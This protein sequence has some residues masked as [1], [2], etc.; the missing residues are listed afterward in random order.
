MS[1]PL[2]ASRQ[3]HM[4][5]RIY[6]F[7]E[8]ELAVA[9][10][11]LRSINGGTI[12]LQ[13]KPLLLLSA[14][15]DNPQKVVT[16]EQLRT[17][18][19][20]SDTFVDHEQGINVAVKKVRGAL[21]DSAEDPKFI[22]TVAKKGYRFLLPVEVESRNGADANSPAFVTNTPTISENNQMAQSVEV[23]RTE[24]T[25]VGV[26]VAG[27]VLLI[28]VGVFLAR[29][30]F[31]PRSFASEKTTLIVIPLDNLSGDPQQEYLSDGITEE[32]TTQLAR[33][34]PNRLAVIGRLTATRYKQSGKDIAQIGKE[35]PVNY[36]LEG[37]I[38]REG[39][40]LRATVQLIEVATQTHVWAEEYD[41]STGDALSLQNEIAAAVAGQIRLKLTPEQEQELASDS[42]GSPAAHD[43]YLRG[44][45]EWNKRDA[46]G[47]YEAIKYF[48]QALRAQP[49][50]APA[51]A[52]LADSYNLL[53]QYGFARPEEAYPQAKVYATKALQLDAGLAEAYTAL[54]DVEIKYDLDWQ[55]GERQFMQA[56]RA[57]PGYAT[58]HLW[59]AEDYLTQLGKREQAIL[60]VRRAQEIEPLSPIVG[61][62][63]AETYYFS[64]D[65]DRAIA[66][67]T[68]VLDVEP[69]FVPALE[70]LGW[71][72]EQKGMLPEAIAAFQKA[73][74]LSGGSDEMKAQ[75]AHAYALAQRT[76]EARSILSQLLEANRKHYVSPYFFAVIYTALGEKES[77]LEWLERTYQA[78][79]IPPLRVEPRFD[80]LRA[81]RRF[82]ELLQRIQG[83]AFVH[84]S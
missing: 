10:A 44:R 38:R 72:Y 29:S 58:A 54:A 49:D 39:H 19:W 73:S 7:A 56:I 52:G 18:M 47:F 68:K 11:E 60:E 75:L 63:A 65:Y 14:L 66:E 76:S 74:E 70:R 53:G 15:L 69:K 61:A 33:L 4:Q 37:S 51:Y 5:D 41:S 79:D 55:S 12:R 20:D 23:R 13:E 59:Y 48:Q 84:S 57:N 26:L 80:S 9:D 2:G 16:R 77:A 67:A 62:I 35:I 45:Y 25:Q 82:Q 50:Y 42:R 17:R 64:R 83:P 71:V 21:G 3:R 78:H 8:F 6:R 28:A 22:Q 31:R 46:D 24:R 30:F 32:I 1:P 43:A 40:L 34:D 36:V 27:L 81:E